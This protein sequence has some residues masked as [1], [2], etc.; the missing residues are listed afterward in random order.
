MQ[1]TG[2]SKSEKYFL[3]IALFYVLYIA[4]PLFSDLV[5]LATYLP[6]VIVTFGLA[7]VFPRTLFSKPVL[8][9]VVYIGLLFLYGISG[10]PIHVNGVEQSSPYMHRIFIEV[11]W[12]LPSVMIACILCQFNNPKLYRIFSRASLLIIAVSFV[13]ILP[14]I[15]AYSNILRIAISNN[16]NIDLNLQGFPSY[17]LMHAYAFVVLPL[18]WI[19]KNSHT[20]FKKTFYLALSLVFVYVIF[21]TYVTT[22]LIV[23]IFCFLFIWLFDPH[24]AQVSAFKFT[25]LGIILIIFFTSSLL[26]DFLLWIR[27]YFEGTAVIGK[28]DAITQSIT[29][30]KIVGGSLTVRADLHTLSQNNFLLNPFVGVGSAGGHSKIWDILGSMGLVV[31]IP[32]IMII[33]SI[34]KLYMRSVQFRDLRIYITAGFIVAFI[35]LYVKGIFGAAGWL[36]MFVLSPAMFIGYNK[37][38][39]KS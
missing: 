31:F 17:T 35:Y 24:Q 13:Y 26:P 14:T 15:T 12:M 23:C 2:L 18:F 3:V 32:F 25:I 21:N 7:V 22:S 30:G 8:W 4:F 33:V 20:F 38:R 37:S 10:H 9:T 27:P 39:Q 11:G 29:A 34:Y 19:T 16:E 1:K 36:F 5:H 28:I 6:G